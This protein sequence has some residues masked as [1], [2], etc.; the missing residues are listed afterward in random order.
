MNKDYF[1]LLT[2]NII[3]ETSIE[4]FQIGNSFDFF[5]NLSLRLKKYFKFDGWTIVDLRKRKPKFLSYS[6]NYEGL[7][8]KELEEK[9]S[10]KEKFLYMQV[11][12]SR[13]WKYVKDL[14]KNSIWIPRGNLVH[15][16]I[17]IPLVFK[18][19][20]PL[21]LNLDFFSE[22]KISKKEKIFL[23]KFQENFLMYTFKISKLRDIF[24]QQYVD[25]LTGLKNRQY[26]LDILNN[27]DLSEK[28]GIIFCDLDKFKSINDQYGH[29]F[30]DEVL[31]I[32][33][34]RMRNL[35]KSTDEVIRFGGDEFIILTRNVKGVKNVIE[36]IKKFIGEREIF[37]DDKKIGVGISCGYAIFPDE[38][39][40][41][42][43][44]LH[45]S[46]MRMYKDKNLNR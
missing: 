18:N 12:N 5:E 42:G 34:K 9:M 21:V 35:V 46:D 43:E 24:N 30:G 14:Q 39:E 44:I 4:S 23:N 13:K 1:D 28:L 19:M 17:G 41:F 45:I 38:S 27:V 2:G 6:K 31:K 10:D 40:D 33:A 37:L 15:S 22:K 32:V 20:E 29:S 3:L 8:L 26:L 16:W 7:N 11:K 25:A 36:R